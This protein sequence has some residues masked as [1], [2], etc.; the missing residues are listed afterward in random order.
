MLRHL[1]PATVY[2][3][4]GNIRNI[5]DQD[6]LVIANNR[7]AVANWLCEGILDFYR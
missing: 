5:R 4:L 2:I 6:R 1:Q 3:E 7:Q